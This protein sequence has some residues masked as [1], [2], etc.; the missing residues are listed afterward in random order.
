MYGV[1]LLISLVLA[2]IY[3]TAA[4]ILYYRIL[5]RNWDKSLKSFFS[6]LFTVISTNGF[7]ALSIL[8]KS[9][10]KRVCNVNIVLKYENSHDYAQIPQRNYTFMNLASVLYA[11][12]NF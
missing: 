8:S 3:R 6:L 9:G 5:G 11:R 12:L 7:Y 10:L 2:S 1:S 4:C